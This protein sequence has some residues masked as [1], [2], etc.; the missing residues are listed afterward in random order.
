MDPEKKVEEPKIE[1][2]S[3]LDA[4]LDKSIKEVRAGNELKPEASNKPENKDEGPTGETGDADPKDKVED[5]S[6]PPKAEDKKEEGYEF[7]VPNKGKFESDESFELR[8]QLLDQ[9]KKRKLAT[10]PEA[11]AALSEEI[12]KTKGQLK[13]LNGADKS[14]NNLNK[15]VDDTKVIEE[16]EAMKADRERLKALGGMTKDEVREE[17]AQERL[18]LDIKNTLDRF[19]DRTAEMKDP[20][21]REV[22][23]D[24]VDRNY[25]WQGKTG[26]ELLTILE[27][28]RENMFKP[29]ETIQER[30]IKGANVAEK[31]NAMGFAGNTGNKVEFSADK[32]QSIEELK[33]TGM[34]EEKAAELVSDDI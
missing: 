30:V 8:I 11:K 24:F 22:F 15:T 21:V 34:S 26:K 32:K 3:E 20:D 18:Q 6:K 23:F 14:I 29:S 27:L 1:D 33:A 25:A 19:V 16:D 13:N 28:A 10:T 9:V 2:E 31:I 12:Q 7:R 4:E 17:M 5:A